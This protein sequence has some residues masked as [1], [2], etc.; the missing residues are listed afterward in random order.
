MRETFSSSFCGIFC[1]KM[2]SKTKDLNAS[3]G[4]FALTSDASIRNKSRN[5]TLDK[6]NS[7]KSLTSAISVKLAVNSILFCWIRKTFLLSFRLFSFF[8]PCETL[9]MNSERFFYVAR[10]I[11]KWK[12]NENF[13]LGNRSCVELIS[14]YAVELLIVELSR[15]CVGE[16]LKEASRLFRKRSIWL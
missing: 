3:W 1:R 15:D 5:L 7:R 16:E 6:F 9:P 4:G 2:S 13:F 8:V 14:G 10:V 11:S 12:R